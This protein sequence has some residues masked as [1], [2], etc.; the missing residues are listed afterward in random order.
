MI[1]FKPP[2][3]PPRENAVK[4]DAMFPVSFKMRV[5]I[6]NTHLRDI[7]LMGPCFVSPLDG[8]AMSEN[9]TPRCICA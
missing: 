5:Y 3:L 8:F 6:Y 4:L 7:V 1:F 2:V 9:R